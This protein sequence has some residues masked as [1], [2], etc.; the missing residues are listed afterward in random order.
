MKQLSQLI[1][2]GGDVVFD[3]DCGV[4]TRIVQI[5]I[6][7]DW[8]KRLRFLASNKHATFDMHPTLEIERARKEI[9]AFDI[10]SGWYGGWEACEWIMLRLPILWVFVPFT[11]I[12]GSQWLGDR[13]YKYIAA[14]RAKISTFLRLN[15][16]R[17]SDNI[18]RT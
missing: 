14:R 9:L 7:L 3:G 2:P 11:L 4:C 12:P 10:R 18:P 1:P 16:C 6:K 5:L 8:A 17:L 13:A 15:A